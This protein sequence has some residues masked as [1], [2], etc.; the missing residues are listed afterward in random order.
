MEG[1]PD[2]WVKPG[3][4]RIHLWEKVKREGSNLL[5][6]ERFDTISGRLTAVYSEQKC[7][8]FGWR[9]V[10]TSGEEESKALCLWLNST[11]AR[12]QL[13]NRRAKKLTY[14]QWSTQHWASIQVPK[15]ERRTLRLLAD[16]WEKLKDE[17]LL[18]MRYAETDP[19]RIA[20][21]AAA[22]RACGLN[23]EDIANWRK[24]LSHEP[25]V[26]NKRAA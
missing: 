4:A 18:E 25:T 6:C 13:L 22:A 7:F 5:V 17:E 14:P 1:T 2:Q 3:G 24:K 23:A 8:G 15:E 9:P 16:A 26:T 11:P 20:I 19:V 21:D 10:A 12:L